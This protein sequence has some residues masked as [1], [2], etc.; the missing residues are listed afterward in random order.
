MVR[1]ARDVPSYGMM[2][3]GQN[4]EMQRFFDHI[5]QQLQGPVHIGT[6]S[7]KT[8]YRII[9]NDSSSVELQRWKDSKWATIF[10]V[11]ANNDMLGVAPVLTSPD[12]TN[13]RITVAD[14]GHL[15]TESL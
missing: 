12:G 2:P 7:K 10:S 5:V 15:V 9:V 11:D 6:G 4:L 1:T 13:W 3:A 8:E 14:D